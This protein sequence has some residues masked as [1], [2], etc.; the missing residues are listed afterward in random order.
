MA[1]L[2]CSRSGW[3]TVR[4]PKTGERIPIDSDLETEQAQRL[5]DRYDAISYEESEEDTDDD[6]E[7]SVE[8]CSVEMTSGDTCGRE[9][10]C[11]YHD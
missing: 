9:R 3:G 10:P 1:R 11:P 6:S 8:T 2:T 5:A 7:Y 4:D